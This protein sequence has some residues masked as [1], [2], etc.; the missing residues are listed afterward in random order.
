MQKKE[1]LDKLRYDIINQDICPDLRK[2]AT[3]LVFGSGNVDAKIMLI[4]E[5]PGKNE[6]LSGE[7][8]VG[9]AGKLL[10]ELLLS[11]ELNREDVYITNIVKYR[12]PQNRDPFPEETVQFLPFLKK[13][14]EIIS[15]DIIITLGRHSMNCFLSN[16]QISKIHGIPR[17]MKLNVNKLQNKY[18]EII[19]IPFFHPAAALYNGG[20][21]DSLFLDFKKVAK[22]L[23]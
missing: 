19:L 8:F 12:P 3:N 15:P 13:Q 16:Q 11:V 18:K 1:M 14:I 23:N 10:N 20:L 17:K 5:A 9:A 4:G 2:Q 6:D 22:Y 7:P 21:R